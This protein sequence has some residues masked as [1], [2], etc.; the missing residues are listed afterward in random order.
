MCFPLLLLYLNSLFFLL[1]L[2]S[3]LFLFQLKYG[4]SYESKREEDLRRKI[5]LQ[6]KEEIARHNAEYELG[7]QPYTRGI[8]QFSDMVSNDF[9]F[10]SIIE[11]SHVSDS[12]TVNY[13]N[14]G[15]DAE[16]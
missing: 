7:M 11:L 3:V 8:N 10:L 6:R 1:F 12:S 13:N 14:S 2:F 15:S 16:E 4:K 9:P 5:F